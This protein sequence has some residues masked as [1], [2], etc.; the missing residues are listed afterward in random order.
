MY[1]TVVILLVETQRSMTDVC[2]I[3]PSNAIKLAGPVAPEARPATSGHPSLAV[4][5][6]Y[7]STDNEAETQRPRALG[8]RGGQEHDLEEGVILEVNES[9]ADTSG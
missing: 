6:V 3:S 1:P 8:S 5:L 7:S 4:G 9:H 2:E